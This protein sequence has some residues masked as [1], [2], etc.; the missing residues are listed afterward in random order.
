M[1]LEVYIFGLPIR[2][3]LDKFE[4]S[5]RDEKYR[6]V[7]TS[8]VNN[9][10]FRE[11][12]LDIAQSN[13]ILSTIFDFIE[14]NR[15]VSLK[16]NIIRF[17]DETFI[18]LGNLIVKSNLQFLEFIDSTNKLNSIIMPFILQSKIKS[19]CWNDSAS[20]EFAFKVE[21][22]KYFTDNIENNYY[23][24]IVD[25]PDKSQSVDEYLVRN[26]KIAYSRFRN[27]ITLLLINR[28]GTLKFIPVDVFR[29]IAKKYYF[30]FIKNQLFFV[31]HL[32]YKNYNNHYFI[33]T[34]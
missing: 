16:F 25:L 23:L 15:I 27:T 24:Q 7:V 18:H 3:Q 9:M 31:F 21:E 11:G 17:E 32:H 19:L 1:D 12:Q 34:Y 14:K 29:I 20:Y 5:K 4:L 33:H 10:Y 30:D 28:F 2:E 26:K 6:M 8:R 13:N 22:L